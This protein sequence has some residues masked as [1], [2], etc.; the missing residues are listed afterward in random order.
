MSQCPDSEVF[1][2][3][4]DGSLPE[5][6]LQELHEHLDD[7]PD[8]TALVI[9]LGQQRDEVDLPEAI[10]RYQIRREIGAGGMGV[11][12]EGYDPELDRA[13]A[14]KLLHPDRASD[15][16]RV[17]RMK[18]EARLLASLS[19]PNIVSI[20]DV[21]T[22]QGQ[23]F[24]T[25]EFVDGESLAQ[26]L[27]GHDADWRRVVEIF[28][29][30]GKGIAAAHAAGVIHRDI[31]PDNILISGKGRVF[32]TDLGL[33]RAMRP[34]L[35]ETR[36]PGERRAKTWNTLTD[37][38]AVLGTPAFMAPEQ[39]QG[40]EVDERTDVFAFCAS[41]YRAVYRKPPFAGRTIFDL[42]GNI[43][44]GE[45]LAPPVGEAPAALFEVIRAGLDPDPE[46]RPASMQALEAALQA[47]LDE[48]PAGAQEPEQFDAAD[49]RWLVASLV[50][51]VVALVGWALWSA[52]APASRTTRGPAK[53][54]P[55]APTPSPPVAIEPPAPLLPSLAI[56]QGLVS[57][58]VD[59]S[60]HAAREAKP[61]RSRPSSSRKPKATH[62]PV[63]HAARVA[64][65][66]RAEPQTAAPT[67]VAPVSLTSRQIC[68]KTHRCSHDAG[69]ITWSV[70]GETH[71]RTFDA[72][73]Y[74]TVGNDRAVFA[75]PW[76]FGGVQLSFLDFSSKSAVDIHCHE[77]HKG[78]VMSL[79]TAEP[80][81]A[82]FKPLPIEWQHLSLTDRNCEDP[83]GKDRIRRWDLVL[84][85]VST[86]RIAGRFHIV[87]EGGGPRK[88]TTL[89]VKGRFDSP[90]NR[91]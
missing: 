45:V 40:A 49:R 81:A 24:L 88:G 64:K 21:G 48:A 89:E 43:C 56:A 8:C 65:P 17:E 58:A 41:L 87:V 35:D 4:L 60:A 20:Y 9:A 91:R 30:A 22:W 12:Y 34:G 31:K 6:Q 53:S 69:T 47:V 61:P 39:Y 1:A 32:V 82:L 55:G 73:A 28:L 84:T 75:L 59:S 66:A 13:V 3:F 62:A 15:A 85:R 14:I 52:R 37:S 77:H 11:V 63:A 27:D 29:E 7:C 78:V 67:A 86:A 36:P 38:H 68:D 10:G 42:A 79:S 74:Y 57:A 51:V 80:R 5:V 23:V 90:L 54:A 19:H 83:R 25:L 26:W 71:T 76:T 46:V 72:M 16:G 18:R 2:A 33:A 70:G 44:R 50:L